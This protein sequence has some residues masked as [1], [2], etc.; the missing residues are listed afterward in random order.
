MRVTLTTSADRPERYLDLDHEREVVRL[1]GAQ[2]ELLG[3]L[4]WETIID[5]I[6]ATAADAIGQEKRSCPRAPVALQV[7]YRSR[8]HEEGVSITRD[9]GA[10][11][12]FIETSTP[13]PLRTELSVDFVL[14]DPP[15]E[16]VRAKARVAWVREVA[17]RIVFLPGMGVQF[18]D[19]HSQ[20]RAAILRLVHSLNASRGSA[21]PSQTSE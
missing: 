1:L 16:H 5:L 20:A 2:D 11:G 14:P 6:L 3:C 21:T 17:E 12:M 15:F 8:D 7:V 13:L 19:I 9:I 18:V 10:G 4:S